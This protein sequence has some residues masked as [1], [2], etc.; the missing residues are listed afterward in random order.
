MI[1]LFEENSI[2]TIYTYSIQL[3]YIVTLL[4]LLSRY[5]RL[6]YSGIGYSNVYTFSSFIFLISLLI[7]LVFQSIFNFFCRKNL[8]FFIDKAFKQAEFPKQLAFSKN[9]GKNVIFC[10]LFQKYKCISNRLCQNKL[11][12]HNN[13]KLV[14]K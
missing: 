8:V 5:I 13:Q 14:G 6:L 9:L 12:C 10:F 7:I 4:F 2:V 11:D 1:Y 3:L